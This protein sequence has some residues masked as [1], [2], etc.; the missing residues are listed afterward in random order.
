MESESDDFFRIFVLETDQAREN[1]RQ[2]IAIAPQGAVISIK[3]KSR[4]LSQNA[5]LWPLLQVISK[6]VDWYGNKLSE[7]E[8]K[9][10]FSAAV[11]KTKVVPGI[12]GG[13][14]VCGQST[15]KMS[16]KKFSQMLEVI[17]AFGASRGI[18]F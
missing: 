12:D 14:V 6:S 8:W 1:A 15:S 11:S 13:F 5:L 7:E 10:V 3:G 17:H 4:S 2:A 9:D 16:M 18:K